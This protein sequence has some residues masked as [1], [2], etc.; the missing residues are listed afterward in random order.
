ME[1]RLSIFGISLDKLPQWVVLVIG[2][3]GVFLSFVTQGTAQ[4]YLWQKTSFRQ[5]I[6]LTLVQFMGYFL[7]SS[8][9]FWRWLAGKER[10]HAP[11]W[12]YAITSTAL[13][14]S[15]MFSNLSVTRLSYPT[16]VLFKSSKLIPVMIGGRLFLGK[17]YSFL[18]VLSVLLMVLGLFG[19]SMSD[20]IS[21]NTFDLVGVFISLLSLAFDAVSSNLQEKALWEYKATQSEV[22][23]MQYF[24]GIL[25]LLTATICTGE[26]QDGFAIAS[27]NWDVTAALLAFAFLGGIGVQ[28][29]YLLI[30]AFGSLV[31]VMVTSTR[32]ATTVTLSFILFPNKRFTIYHFLSI[33]AV[34]SGISLNYYAKNLKKKQMESERVPLLANRH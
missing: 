18:E 5:A 8:R 16:A 29:V 1:K 25:I 28:F 20:K 23:S 10:S 30:N 17:H 13:V 33:C 14:A 31:A 7:L 15:M 27:T 34:A 2:V 22:I 24:I 26:F 4:E 32:K 9:F 19:I 3:C 12:Y 6:F 11:L 21:K